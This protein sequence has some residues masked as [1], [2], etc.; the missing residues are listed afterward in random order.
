MSDY[1]EY[2][3]YDINFVLSHPIVADEER[4][5]SATASVVPTHI[6]GSSDGSNRICGTMSQPWIVDAPDGQRIRISLLDF[7]A[8][9]S[10]QVLEQ[11]RL[12]CN[13]YGVIVDKVSKRNNTICG[14]GGQR[15]IEVY[16]STGNGVEIY[17]NPSSQAVNSDKRGQFLL[18]VEGT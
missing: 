7:R 4:S 6:V 11:T 9:T 12:P 10:G 14:G 5:C 2:Y 16:T 13:S 1:N 18:K 17:L 15:E 3:N 8:S